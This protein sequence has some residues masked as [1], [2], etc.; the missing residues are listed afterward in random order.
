[1]KKVEK[2]EADDKI[3]EH[4][5]ATFDVLV[6]KRKE[7]VLLKDKN[8]S[9]KKIS[10]NTHACNIKERHK[11]QNVALELDGSEHALSIV[12]EKQDNHNHTNTSPNNDSDIYEN[13]KT[14]R[15]PEIVSRCADDHDTIV[16]MDNA[17]GLDLQC[18]NVFFKTAN[19]HSFNYSTKRLVQPDS[20]S[21]KAVCSFEVVDAESEPE[22][23]T[24]HE[25][26]PDKNHLMSSKE[27]LLE[28][29]IKIDRSL[30]SIQDGNI[31]KDGQNMKTEETSKEDKKLQ[32][33]KS[34]QKVKIGKAMKDLAKT[35][36]RS[37][38]YISSTDD[39][40]LQEMKTKINLEKET[41]N[42][43]I[44][45]DDI[46]DR[47]SNQ[48]QVTDSTV[49]DQSKLHVDNDNSDE[50]KTNVK[51]NRSDILNSNRSFSK[52]QGS[53][54]QALSLD[55]SSSDGDEVEMIY[56]SQTSKYV[57]PSV[58]V[59]FDEGVPRKE[60]SEASSLDIDY[61]A[62]GNR[63]R[64]C[65]A[66]SKYQKQ[67]F[68]DSDTM[69]PEPRLTQLRPGI[70]DHGKLEDTIPVCEDN[71]VYDVINATESNATCGDLDTQKTCYGITKVETALN[72]TDIDD[73]AD[74]VNTGKPN[75]NIP[76]LKLNSDETIGK[77][78]KRGRIQYSSNR[79]YLGTSVPAKIK[80]RP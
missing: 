75:V 72:V 8:I 52:V 51:S 62:H 69:L 59:V 48:T 61:F 63:R 14:P 34:K 71:A 33:A 32:K 58:D 50:K 41:K 27:I 77:K 70:S 24:T 45:N 3:T 6:D 17:D 44:G 78:M 2:S 21:L 13:E 19:S 57:S 76:P 5:T 79:K 16:E 9:K 23:D 43:P 20:K 39:S 30:P 54:I 53:N 68:K 18:K 36:Q 55:D 7:R 10:R 64:V 15:I 12:H 67:N 40:K 25:S 65:N 80:K 66:K 35:T 56:Q 73:V 28:E 22:S 74:D 37:S 11:Q 1:M 29:M 46:I 38:K 26:E 31:T 60:T 4:N 47:I 49:L 42:T